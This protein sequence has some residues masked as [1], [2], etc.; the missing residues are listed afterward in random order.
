MSN[1]TSGNIGQE[2]RENMGASTNSTKLRRV[3]VLAFALLA[4]IVMLAPAGAEA[5]KI[6][7][8]SPPDFF[9]EL[10]GGFIQLS[11]AGGTKVFQLSLDF[12][13]LGLSRPSFRGTI[14]SAGNI[15]VPQSQIVFPPLSF[16]IPPDTV[17]LTL[18][19][20][21]PA[22]GRIDPLTGRVDFRVRLRIQGTGSAQGVSLGGSCFVG[23]VAE[24]ID[25]DGRTHN[26]TFPDASSIYQATFLPDPATGF[27]GG[28][29]PAGPYSD[30]AGVWE[31]G[32]KPGGVG[33]DFVPRNAGS[34]RIGNDTLRAIGATGCG[35]LGLANGPLNDQVGLPSDPGGSTA[36][37]DFEFVVGGSRTGPNAIVQ[38]G[39]KSNFIAPGV[40]SP[41]W[42]STE[43]PTLP[44]TVPATIDASSSVFTAGPNA[45]G[46]YSFD[47]GTGSFGGFTDTAVQPITYATPG[48][49]TIRVRARDADGDIDVKSRQ[50]EIVPST[51]I[52]VSAS[53]AAEFRGGSPGTVTATVNNTSTT[54]SNTQPVVLTTSLPAGVTFVSTNAPAGWNC[55]FSAPTVTCTLPTGSLAAGASSAVN[56]NVDVAPNAATPRP[57]SFNVDQS[58]DP[59]SSNNNSSV[60]VNVRKTDLTVAISHAGDVVA[61]GT[62]SHLVEVSNAGDA[63][64]S[65]D[66]TVSITLPPLLS[67]RNAGSGGSGWSCV[68]GPTPQDVTC[69]RSAAIAANA[70][71][72]PFNVVAKV[73]RTA[74]GTVV[75]N[76]SVS[77]Q[78]DTDAFAGSNAATDNIEV[79][80]R[81]DVALESS[82]S[83]NFVV[84]DPGTVTF[85]VTNES[86]VTTGGPTQVTSTLPA[87]LTVATATG[88]G[89][90]CSATVLGSSDVDCSYGAD[91]ADGE[92]APDL[93]VQLAVDHG[94]YPS[95]TIDSALTNAV[96]AYAPNN[97]STVS[98]AVKRLDVTISKSAVRSFSVGLEGQYRL[99][100]SNIGDTDTVGPVTVLDELPPELKL[101]SASG[102]GWNCS[103]SVVGGQ[104]VSCVLSS[105]IPAGGSAAVINVKV[106]VLDA[107]ADVGEVINTATVDTARDNRSVSAD[108]PVNGNNSATATTKAVSV[109]LAIDSTHG[110]VFRVGTIQEYSLKIRNVGV[111]PTLPGEPVTVTAQIP[112]G[113][114]PDTGAIL[115]DRPGWSCG[116][117]DQTVTCVLEAPSPTGT[118]MPAGQTA[119]I[120]I[121]VLVTDAAVDPSVNVVEVAT[122]KDNSVER[123]PNNRS[124]DPTQV[125][126]I[127]LETSASVSIP[128]RAGSIGEVSVDVTNIGSAATATPTVVTVPLATGTSYR[129]TGST[130]VGWNCSS[131]GAGTQIT[132]TRAPSVAAGGSAPPLKLRTNVT[133]SAPTSWSTAIVVRSV[134]EA[135]ER[136][137]N[138]DPALTQTLQRIDLDLNRSHVGGS[139]KSG[140]RGQYTIN[141]ANVGN[142]AS[143]GTTTVT[144]TLP[145][146][147]S[148]ISGAGPGWNCQTSGQTLSCT[149]IAPVGAGATT[150]DIVV[151]FDTSSSASGTRSLNASMSN[152]SDPYPGNNTA[153]DTIMIVASADVS[154]SID[155]PASMRIGDVSSIAY[156]VRNVGTENTSGSPSVS[157]RVT[158]SSDL[159]PVGSN[160]EDDWECSQAPASGDGDAT[161]DCVLPSGL[162]PGDSSI[163]NTQVR[164]LP[165]GG[166]QVGTLA[167]ISSPGDVFRSND[168]ALALSDVSGVDLSAS[169]SATT[170]DLEAGIVTPRL[171][172][173]TNA[174]SAAT[175]GPITVRVPLPAGVQWSDTPP[176]GSGWACALPA[177]TPRAV[178]CDRTDVLGPGQSLTPL[179]ID[180]KPSRSNAP[181]ITVDY[182]VS[183]PGDSNSANDTATREDTVLFKPETTIT[184]KPSGTTTART[185]TIEFTSDDPAATFECKLDLG[186]FEPCTSP[187]NL[188]GVSLGGHSFTV[189]A[190][191]ANDMLDPTPAEANWTVIAD[192]PIGDSVPLKA[193]LTGGNLNIAALGAV[194]LPGGQ[195]TL[196]GSL[197][198]NGAWSVPQAGVN[199]LPIEQTID[200]PGIGQ[201]TVKIAI[202]ATGPGSGSLP[203][204]GGA[205]TF[206][207]PVQAKLEARLG[208]VPLIG[209]D[210]DCFLRPIQFELS[211]T[212]DEGAQTATVGSPSV[213]FPQVSAGCGAIGGTVNSLLELPRSD[214]G[215]SLNFDL[216]KGSAGTPV[217][218]KPTVR[219][220]K[221][222]KAG[223]PVTLRASIRN[224][225]P[226]PATAVRVCFTAKT[227]S[228]VQGKPRVCRTVASIEA[229][230][231]VN[232][233]QK[234]RT[235]KGRKGK[236]VRFEVSAE[237]SKEGSGKVITRTG[238]VT[239]MK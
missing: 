163:L 160:S 131:P 198:E 11:G 210:A 238:H 232:L 134:G 85:K 51:D 35:P 86:V 106:D 177:G 48:I 170:Q 26:G 234:F 157:L 141:V 104:T 231:S 195:L 13:E 5:R 217:I 233:S 44:T 228:L 115:T 18:L 156:Q 174:G 151:S 124:E 235:K 181:S 112:A 32:P 75:T 52:G 216:E 211:G 43:I 2:A 196:D 34:F 223:K 126:R 140:L 167:R 82:V 64:T 208:N 214:I 178:V 123:S 110:S 36:V 50:I 71:A 153:S 47:L 152:P 133:P 155:Q 229:G 219:A 130:I 220:P 65:G 76:A 56:V 1:L 90:D 20:T 37:L 22:T 114:V 159:E 60:D 135:A 14:D 147:F 40:S 148:N 193:D 201:V 122:E 165:T 202:S 171:V 175:T 38:K 183:T 81:P 80:V 77:G 212:Y 226:V 120:D 190:K 53:A 9:A 116:A 188:T 62:V 186:A 162:A 136:L 91:L 149:R 57:F 185:A 100:V 68:S 127:D 102:G 108:D 137:G 95:V 236:R 191:N 98:T 105:T 99:S 58:G 173:V 7:N 74:T 230:K 189:R 73:D 239:L 30:E 88:S 125:S 96:D 55:S 119:T 169:V 70:S 28:I 113:M 31:A 24:P 69:T 197:F 176:Y 154:V 109:D 206:N 172:T 158:M 192:T 164:V 180:L 205:A 23:S 118:A 63:P 6:A 222:V 42:P 54:R 15:N 89:W 225:G 101:R 12:E 33:Y 17:N 187:V 218:A 203:N 103:A 25:I 146:A 16:E 145:P 221:S 94:A 39:V 49:R 200:A 142:V 144:E 27:P 4:A 3:A 87:G 224:A 19:P 61:N 194:D 67:Y 179:R 45:G 204:G 199:F 207:L 29:Q 132:C 97:T 46:R 150:P 83:G 128:P 21:A 78:G 79:L 117:V 72:P 184:T 66:T 227:R 161:F 143:T 213:T 138:N 8:P 139:I 93:S 111:F 166:S 41:T 92:V 215:I 107:A 121:P 129:P 59:N 84:G 10:T 168:S 209:P 182:T 237:Y